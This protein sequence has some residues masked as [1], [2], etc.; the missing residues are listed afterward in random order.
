MSEKT[1]TRMRADPAETERCAFC[2]QT[3]AYE[4]E[5]RCRDCDHPMCHLCAVRV[6]AATV[7]VC[8][9]DCAPA[10]GG[11]GGRAG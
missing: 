3:Y 10:E 6:R 5:I 8:C 7:R 1:E 2:L 11:R 9:P 4:A